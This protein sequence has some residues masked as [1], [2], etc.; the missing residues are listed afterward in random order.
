[1]SGVT[2]L[3][4]FHS[5]IRFYSGVTNGRFWYGALATPT[6]NTKV[7]DPVSDVTNLFSFH[8]VITCSSKGFVTRGTLATP[9]TNTKVV[10]TVSEFTNLFSF[11]SIVFDVAGWVRR[12]IL[13]GNRNVT[14]LGTRYKL[15][16]DTKIFFHRQQTGEIQLGTRGSTTVAMLEKGALF[17]VSGFSHAIRL[18]KEA[19]V[20]LDNSG[21]MV[22]YGSE[23][24][25][26]I[27]AADETKDGYT[28][29]TGSLLSLHT[30]GHIKQG[31]LATNTSPIEIPSG[32]GSR[33]TFASNTNLSFYQDGSVKTG[34]LAA[35]VDV[36]ILSVDYRLTGVITFHDDET[37]DLDNTVHTK[38]G[39]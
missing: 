15:N 14:L 31:M 10:D 37:V 24:V 23:I 29:K 1:M 32:S 27:G 34:T 26:T 30:N 35:S 20:N 36:S 4:S 22:S 17:T 2:N 21:A 25:G 5:K 11:H 6:T 19:T 28:Y 33:Y 3:F 38:I 12:G 8:K 9:T 13:A 39:E 16:A 7:V 18:T